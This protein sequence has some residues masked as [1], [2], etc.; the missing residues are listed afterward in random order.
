MKSHR[1]SIH[2]R[3]AVHKLIDAAYQVACVG[4]G[5]DDIVPWNVN[6]AHARADKSYRKHMGQTSKYGPHQGRKECARRRGLR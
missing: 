2:D 1:Y 3:K 6:I 5:T 4:L